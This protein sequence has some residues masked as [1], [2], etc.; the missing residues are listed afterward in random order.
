MEPQNNI[1]NLTL[2][3]NEFMYS[4]GYAFY[5]GYYHSFFMGNSQ[6]M[7]YISDMWDYMIKKSLT[8]IIIR[9]I[10]ILKRI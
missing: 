3:D 8:M 7:N 1:D 6:H 5:G 4:P 10:F 2:L 9:I